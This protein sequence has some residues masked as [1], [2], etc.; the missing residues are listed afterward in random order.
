MLGPGAVLGAVGHAEHEVQGQASRW[1]PQVGR[2]CGG[3]V[4]PPNQ[5]SA[6]TCPGP[7][8]S[9]EGHGH[10]CVLEKTHQR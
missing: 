6:F 10:V 3:R 1:A 9:R 7:G 2:A 8:D 5:E 4:S